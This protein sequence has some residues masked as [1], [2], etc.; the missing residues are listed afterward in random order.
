MNRVEKLQNQLPE[1]RLGH[2]PLDVEV[3]GLM[4]TD[5]DVLD[6]KEQQAA[7]LLQRIALIRAGFSDDQVKRAMDPQLSFMAGAREEIMAKYIKAG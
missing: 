4:H 5:S 2:L 3:A 1:D 6:L 7:A